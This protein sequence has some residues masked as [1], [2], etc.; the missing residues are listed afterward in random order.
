MQLPVNKK[1]FFF[2]IG[3][4]FLLIP[5]SLIFFSQPKQ[6]TQENTKQ[7]EISK[8]VPSPNATEPKTIDDLIPGQTTYDKAI[9]VLGKPIKVKDIDS[10]SVLYYPSPGISRES[11]VYLSNDVVMYTI[12]EVSDGDI[13]PTYLEEHPTIE[14]AI[15]NVYDNNVGYNLYIF[16][17]LGVAFLV[18]DETHY[19]AEI[20]R[21]APTTKEKY[22]QLFAPTLTYD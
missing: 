18:H 4:V 13:Y 11:K 17:S 7:D 22:F 19:T 6:S 5:L 15:Y 8:L 12:K 1:V 3:G 21:F 20:H 14:G 16:A 9:T 2:L 10:Y